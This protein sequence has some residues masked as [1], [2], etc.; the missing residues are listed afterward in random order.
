MPFNNLESTER[1]VEAALLYYLETIQ[2]AVDTQ[3]I[4]EL[5]KKLGHESPAKI[6]HAMKYKKFSACRR[7]AKEILPTLEQ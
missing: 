4:K 3:G 6:Q 7:L 5:S 2:R 1:A